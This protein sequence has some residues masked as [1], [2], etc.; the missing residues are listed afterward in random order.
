[1]YSQFK[2]RQL[3]LTSLSLR[4]VPGMLVNTEIHL[5]TR[6]VLEYHLSPVQKVA[7]S[8]TP[9]P[10]PERRGEMYSAESISRSIPRESDGGWAGALIR[11]VF[12]KWQLRARS[13]HWIARLVGIWFSRPRIDLDQAAS[14]NSLTASQRRGTFCTVSAMRAI[15]AVGRTA[16][17]WD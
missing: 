16:E 10:S 9:S 8:L 2:R 4:L 5:G 7:S 6:S 15:A 11:P 14:R 17:M 1:M 3:R 12:S 13:G